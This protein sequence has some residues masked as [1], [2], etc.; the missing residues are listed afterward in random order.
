MISMT[1][2]L[3]G[4]NHPVS[5]RF[6]DM[7]PKGDMTCQLGDTIPN[8]SGIR[9]MSPGWIVSPGWNPYPGA[10]IDSLAGFRLFSRQ[11]RKSQPG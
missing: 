6:G 3:G 1:L 11:A 7:I 8:S 4:R 5:C 2:P 10:G 9:V